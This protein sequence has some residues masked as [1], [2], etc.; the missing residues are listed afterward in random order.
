[1]LEWKRFPGREKVGSRKEGQ[2]L[3]QFLGV[4]FGGD[5]SQDRRLAGQ[6]GQGEG[7]GSGRYHPPARGEAIPPPLLDQPRQHYQLNSV[8]PMWD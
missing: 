5:E 2:I 6:A 7:A 3:D 1:M 8:Q 4:A